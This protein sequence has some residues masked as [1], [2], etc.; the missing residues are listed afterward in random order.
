[1]DPLRK[2]KVEI[3]IAD[4]SYQQIK[5]GLANGDR[6]ISGPNRILRNLEDGDKVKEDTGTTKEKSDKK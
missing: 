5:T 1:M 3:G 4:D 6:I 2:I